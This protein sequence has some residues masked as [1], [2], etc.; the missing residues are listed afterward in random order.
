MKNLDRVN[1]IIAYRHSLDPA[2]WL[3]DA[4][5]TWALDSKRIVVFALAYR[6][7]PANEASLTFFAVPVESW[8][9][10]IGQALYDWG[11]IEVVD[12]DLCGSLVEEEELATGAW[13]LALCQPAERFERSIAALDEAVEQGLEIDIDEL[14]QRAGEWV[15]HYRVDPR[16]ILRGRIVD[17]FGATIIRPYAE[18]TGQDIDSQAR[19]AS[20]TNVNVNGF[21]DVTLEE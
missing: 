1:A 3:A 20:E 16:E 8:P 15:E 5:V 6:D 18:P 4:G 7:Y 17:T 10:W 19:P 12:N 11:E 9:K 2:D 13:L 21:D 14:R